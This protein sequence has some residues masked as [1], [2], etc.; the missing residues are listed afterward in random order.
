MLIY[1]PGCSH[2][3]I[4]VPR[5]YSEVYQPLQEKGLEVFAI[6]TMDDRKAWGDFLTEHELFEW[7]N[8]WD[9]HH[10]SRFRILYDARKTPGIYVLDEEKTIVAKKLSI[11]QLKRFL[12]NELNFEGD[13]QEETG[14]GV[15]R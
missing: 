15:M 4:F 12:Y 9:E 5:L 11:D 7:I 1:E 3:N 6:Y 13:K 14:D 10:V 2:C 8:V